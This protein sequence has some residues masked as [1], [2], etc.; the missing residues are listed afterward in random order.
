MEK[1]DVSTIKDSA[2]YES[3]EHV[4]TISDSRKQVYPINDPISETHIVDGVCT[5]SVRVRLLETAVVVG[6][7]IG[8]ITNVLENSR[9]ELPLNSLSPLNTN[10]SKAFVIG[11]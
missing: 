3:N 10:Q 7:S 11:S 6:G 8:P 2:Y 9:M 5:L 4:D 1:K